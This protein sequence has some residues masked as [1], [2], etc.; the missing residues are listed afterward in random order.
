M[1][2]LGLTPATDLEWTLSWD[3]LS[4]WKGI[5]LPIHQYAAANLLHMTYEHCRLNI[6]YN[7]I[8]NTIILQSIIIMY[9]RSRIFSSFLNAKNFLDICRNLK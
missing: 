5:P 2:L 8:Y 1:E 9:T 4:T 6:Y 7:I 3:E